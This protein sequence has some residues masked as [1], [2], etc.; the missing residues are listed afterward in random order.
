MGASLVRELAQAIKC[1]VHHEIKATPENIAATD[2]NRKLCDDAR[3]LDLVMIDVSLH[4]EEL[5]I[6]TA[7]GSLG[8]SAYENVE[9]FFREPATHC[10]QYGRLG[11]E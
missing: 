8:L 9:R 11:N 2:F 1:F 3:A 10:K 4:I 5:G 6:C 7:D